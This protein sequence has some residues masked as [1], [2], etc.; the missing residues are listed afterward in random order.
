[1]LA[2]HPSERADAR[3]HGARPASE[4]A[5]IHRQRA[6]RLR[7]RLARTFYAAY[8]CRLGALHELAVGGIA[9][10]RFA[11]RSEAYDRIGSMLIPVDTEGRPRHEGWVAY[12]R[13]FEDGLPPDIREER[14]LEAH[15]RDMEAV[16]AAG[17]VEM[18]AIEAAA[19][20]GDPT[21]EMLDEHMAVTLGTRVQDQEALSG[22]VPLETAIATSLSKVVR[23]Q[24]ATGMALVRTYAGG[25]VRATLFGG[26]R[27]RPDLPTD[28]ALVCGLV[29]ATLRLARITRVWRLG[30]R[31]RTRGAERPGAAWSLIPSMRRAIGDEVDRLHPDVFDMFDR[32]H[33]WSMTARVDLHHVVGSLA[34]YFAALLV[35][36]GMYEEHLD[37][38][39]A[40]FRLFRRDDGS[41]HFVREFWC[42][43]AVRVFDSDFVVR[44][45]DGKDT[46]VEVFQDLGVGAVMRTEVLPDGGL[47]MTVVR[48]FIRG[49]SQGVGP[50]RVCFETRP[51]DDGAVD[52]TGV[53]DL[54]PRNALERWWLRSGMG[55]PDRV[56][57]ISYRAVRA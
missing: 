44:Q 47:S 32:M 43:D 30:V 33:A 29:S 48:L 42:A 3:R 51:R 31:R 36:Q 18:F 8:P 4:A 52:V 54:Q 5:F 20:Q 21:W 57:E 28:R 14:W 41:L 45:V 38:V 16:K 22:K 12:V 49:V 13:A 53:L 37:D 27:T 9:L 24:L 1:M 34:A 11:A 56:G 19:H 15:L 10:A 23:R 46:L 40:R 7:C 50:F 2:P 55:L 26:P 25:A 17:L 39:P 6:A 35:G